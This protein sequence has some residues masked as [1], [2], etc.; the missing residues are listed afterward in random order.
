[1]STDPVAALLE[2][3]SETGCVEISELTQLAEQLDLGDDEITSLYE[4]LEER[5]IDVRDDCGRQ[6]VRAART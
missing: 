5:G 1:M 3:G 6:K 4:Q 2:H